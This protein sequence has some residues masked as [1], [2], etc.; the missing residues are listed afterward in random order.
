MDH[1][2]NEIDISKQVK[3]EEL[4]NKYKIQNAYKIEVLL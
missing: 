2:Y 3:G 1:C 4:S